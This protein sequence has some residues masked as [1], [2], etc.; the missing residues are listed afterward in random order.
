MN[1]MDPCFFFHSI[2]VTMQHVNRRQRKPVA[3]RN[4]A[5]EE[6]NLHTF[7]QT[8]PPHSTK[9]NSTSKPTK[10]APWVEEKGHCPALSPPLIKECRSWHA[11]RQATERNKTQRSYSHRNRIP[12]L[13]LASEK[14]RLISHLDSPITSG[15]SLT[16]KVFALMTMGNHG[17]HNWIW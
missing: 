11:R 5:G 16:P 4:R 7:V 15:L 9:W 17:E 13:T 8:T 2:A 6:P 14:R 12:V 10:P 3:E 1:V